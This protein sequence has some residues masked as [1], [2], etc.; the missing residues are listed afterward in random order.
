[1]KLAQ[2]IS[3][4]SGAIIRSSVYD[5]SSRIHCQAQRTSVRGVRQGLGASR[6][7]VIII[8]P[9]CSTDRLWFFETQ[10]QVP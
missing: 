8:K 9:S 5:S 2:I 1:V 7:A 3:I 6:F 4:S 10:T